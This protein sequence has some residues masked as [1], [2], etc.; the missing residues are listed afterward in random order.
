[1]QQASEAMEAGGVDFKKRPKK[2]KMKGLAFAYNPDGYWV[3]LVKRKY[4]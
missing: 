4:A 3:E 2:G 1:M